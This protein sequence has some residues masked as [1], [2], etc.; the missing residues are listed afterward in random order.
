MSAT[1]SG[2]ADL[3]CRRST[4]VR[5][6]TRSSSRMYAPGA[7]R[8]G[9]LGPVTVCCADDQ[10]RRRSHRRRPRRHRPTSRD[11]SVGGQTGRSW[12]A[13]RATTSRSPTPGLRR[14]GRWH[15]PAT[16]GRRRDRPDRVAGCSVA[17]VDSV[18]TGGGRA[19]LRRLHRVGPPAGAEPERP[20]AAG[21]CSRSLRETTLVAPDRVGPA[22]SPEEFLAVYGSELA[23]TVTDAHLASPAAA[24]PRG[25]AGRRCRWA[26][27]D[28]GCWV[29]RPT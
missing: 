27:F 20:G 17:A 9:H 15:G 5:V 24:P 11:G 14:L 13:C 19:R 12:P 4:S 21:A 7:L 6:V 3:A 28:C 2:C 16:A 1:P 10:R 18:R 26:A 23:P 25:P 22:T 8:D 29:T